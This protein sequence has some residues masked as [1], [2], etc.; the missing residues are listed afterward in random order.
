VADTDMTVLV[1][2]SREFSALLDDVAGLS[3]KLLATLAARV[4]DL[5]AQA[6]G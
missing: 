5:D 1:L 6:Y 2:G 4:R 3:H